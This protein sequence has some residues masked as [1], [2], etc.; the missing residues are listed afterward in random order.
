MKLHLFEQLALP[1]WMSGKGITRNLDFILVIVA[2][3]LFL[4]ALV[5]G[6]LRVSGQVYIIPGS[7]FQVS[8]RFVLVVDWVALVTHERSWWFKK[9]SWTCFGVCKAVLVAHRAILVD[10]LVVLVGNRTKT[11]PGWPYNQGQSVSHQGLFINI[12]EL[13]LSLYNP[14]HTGLRFE[15]R[16]NWQNGVKTSFLIL[17]WLTWN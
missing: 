10:F 3:R 11:T 15:Y 1:N 13:F 2:H 8:H 9:H 4:G 6:S 7:L 14:T 17:L 12:L 5:G 16:Q